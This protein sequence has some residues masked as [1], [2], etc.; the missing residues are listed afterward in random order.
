MYATTCCYSISLST[1][2]EYG[3]ETV[4]AFKIRDIIV[5]FTFLTPQFLPKSRGA[6]ED[7]YVVSENFLNYR[8][9]SF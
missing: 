9:D 7:G 6:G 8:K 3:K 4:T 1:S 5:V 2:F